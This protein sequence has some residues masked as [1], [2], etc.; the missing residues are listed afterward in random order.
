MNRIIEIVVSPQGQTTVLTKG[1]AGASCQQASRFLEASLGRRLNETL[2]SEFYQSVAAQ[3]S[4][5][6]KN[7]S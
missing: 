5:Q 3:Q 1:F 2:T 6:Q 4:V 7:Q